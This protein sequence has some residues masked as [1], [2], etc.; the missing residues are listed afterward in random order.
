MTMSHKASA[1]TLRQQPFFLSLGA[2]GTFADHAQAARE[3]T[4]E[5]GPF[6][7]GCQATSSTARNNCI[8]GEIS[9]SHTSHINKRFL[10]VMIF[11]QGHGHRVGFGGVSAMASE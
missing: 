11:F 6:C 10:Y 4:E 7:G 9:P 5:S 2:Q 1:S 3:T 8:T